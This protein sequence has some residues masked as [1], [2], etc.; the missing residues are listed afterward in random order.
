MDPTAP[1]RINTG[2]SDAMIIPSEVIGVAS[3]AQ[4]G[5]VAVFLR[6]G[7]MIGMSGTITSVCKAIGWI[8]TS[9][10]PEGGRALTLAS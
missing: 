9:T 5:L 10:P 6:G 1:V 8:N 2:Q 4:P 7:G 3:T